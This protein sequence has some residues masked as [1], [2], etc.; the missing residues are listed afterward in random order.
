M[1]KIGGAIDHDPPLAYERTDGEGRD[2]FSAPSLGVSHAEQFYRAM[3]ESEHA[4][5]KK[6]DELDPPGYGGITED[7]A[8]ATS[9]LG[10]KINPGQKNSDGVPKDSVP[11]SHLVEFTIPGNDFKNKLEAAGV[12]PKSELKTMSYGMGPAQHEGLG[13]KLLNEAIA[14]GGTHRLVGV[15]KEPGE[16]SSAKFGKPLTVKR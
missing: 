2:R 3:S 9:Y 8:Y 5:L 4:T 6:T 11:Y 15:V 14:H 7:R 10:K 16:G 13:G 12:N 1:P